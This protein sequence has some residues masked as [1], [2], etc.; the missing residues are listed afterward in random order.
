MSAGS[1]RARGHANG[2]ARAES[3]WQPPRGFPL[4]VRRSKRSKHLRLE[5][6]ADAVHVVAP[7]RATRA[8]IDQ[9]VYE[10]RSWIEAGVREMRHVLRNRI[11]PGRYVSGARLPFG[12]DT[13]Q[14]EVVNAKTERTANR[15]CLRGTTLVA[16]VAPDLRGAKREAEAKALIRRWYHEELRGAATELVEFHGPRLGLTPTGI[17][18]KWMTT[19]WGSCGPAGYLNLNARLLGAPPEV[20]EYVVVHELCHLRHLHHQPSFWRLVEEAL[21]NYY[22]A[23]HWLDRNG[24]RLLVD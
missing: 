8:E 7:T 2:S 17:R 9:L 10:K 16:R 18:V 21:P 23:V 1:A 11:F 13:L 4:R 22:R 20:L 3:A 15:V 24:M 14:L 6:G 19:R 5:I 12:N